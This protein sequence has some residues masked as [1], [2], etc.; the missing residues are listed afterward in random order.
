MPDEQIIEVIVRMILLKSLFKI[1]ISIKHS[2]HLL[3]H[4]VKNKEFINKVVLRLI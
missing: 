4:W 3:I 2:K 1:R